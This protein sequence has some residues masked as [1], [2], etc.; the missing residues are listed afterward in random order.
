[1]L[2]SDLLAYWQHGREDERA[3]QIVQEALAE[4]P[5]SA[6]VTA[7]VLQVARRTELPG[8]WAERVESELATHLARLQLRLRQI[9]RIGDAS[10]EPTILFQELGEEAEAINLERLD[11]Q[12]LR[13]TRLG[14]GSRARAAGKYLTA[15]GPDALPE[16][17]AEALQT[18]I[19]SITV[20]I[21]RGELAQALLVGEQDEGFVIGLQLKLTDQPQINT[22]ENVD[23]HLRIAASTAIREILSEGGARFGMEWTLPFEGASIG[24]PM[25]LATLVARGTL[26]AD[27]LTAATG[28]VHAGGSVTGVGGITAKLAAAA[29]AGIRRVVLPEENRRE[30]EQAAA[31][32][33]ELRFIANVSQLSGPYECLGAA[34]RL[35]S[36]RSGRWC[37]RYRAASATRSPTSGPSPTATS[38]SSRV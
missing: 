22:E 33:L 12:A 7:R 29:A 38:S 13:S 3:A 14:A 28:H 10:S 11:I 31:P 30:A 21:S 26:E 36:P 17:I 35:A 15:L 6:K 32:G 9:D 27:P 20:Q 1:M 19:A 23:E 24:L 2:D 34:P 25:A 5:S 16:P 4:P 8:A 37:A 18:A